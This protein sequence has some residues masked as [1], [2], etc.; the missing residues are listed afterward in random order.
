MKIIIAI[1]PPEKLACVK[2][3]LKKRDMHLRTVSEV[4]DC[5][6]EG[7]R[8]IYR[9]REVRQPAI[10]LRLEIAVDEPFVKLAI[11]AIEH[12]GVPGGS[13]DVKVFVTQIDDRGHDGHSFKG[14]SLAVGI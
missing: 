11:E 5:G 13:S 2:S 4:L 14:T 8:E 9:G 1:I 12:C 6:D 7:S 10:K 3:A